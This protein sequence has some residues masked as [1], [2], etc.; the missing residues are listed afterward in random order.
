[1]FEVDSRDFDA[2]LGNTINTLIRPARDAV[3]YCCCMTCIYT[4]TRITIWGQDLLTTPYGRAVFFFLV[5][6]WDY[7][8]YH[9]TVPS[10]TWS[11][12]IQQY[13][14]PTAV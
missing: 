13:D 6:W 12:Q 7:R 14:T 11:P 10:I 9:P 3:G 2:V 5:E 1:M 8:Q 4:S